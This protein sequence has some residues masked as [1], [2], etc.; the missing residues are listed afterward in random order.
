MGD[1]RTF[2][3]N[4]TAGVGTAS[5]TPA[6]THAAS[7]IEDSQQR[8]RDA[9]A[10]NL[11]M[12]QDAAK[13]QQLI[14]AHF[15]DP[16]TGKAY[17]QYQPQYDEAMTRFGGLAGQIYESQYPNPDSMSF[18]HKMGIRALSKM[19]LTNDLNSRIDKWKKHEAQFKDNLAAGGQLPYGMTPEGDAE[20]AKS[21]DSLE[22]Q[23]LRNQ[24]PKGAQGRP[25]PFGKGSISS[26]DA[27][28]MAAGGMVFNN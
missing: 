19:H 4:L 28:E 17:P 26:K 8:Q 20:A 12:L 18:E 23:R 15:T 3:Q 27:Q 7:V 16:T 25:V 5:N 11:A 24:A 2:L 21:R 1:I 6:G 9:Q 13:K 22:L 10:Q 14:A